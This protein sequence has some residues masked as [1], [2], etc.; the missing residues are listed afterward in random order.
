MI[1][2]GYCHCGISRYR[3]IEDVVAA[4]DAAGVDAAVL[5]QHLGEFDNGYLEAVA[6]Q[7]PDRFVA[8]GLVDQLCTGSWAALDAMARAAG[9][10]GIR[11]TEAA[12]SDSFP[13]CARAVELGL[14]ALLDLPSG[15]ARMRN[16]V[17]RLA[18]AAAGRPIVISH[19]GYP[20]VDGGE[21]VR[22]RAILEL[23]DVASTHVLV[24]G[25]GMFCEFPYPELQALTVD[26]VQRY[27]AERVMWGSN[28]PESVDAATYRRDLD[29][30]TGLA[31]LARPQLAT[32]LAGETARRVW[33]EQ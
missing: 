25:F 4:M 7:R 21:L 8:V 9:I 33:F 22:G 16:E 14:I 1:V 24:S 10:R 2:D 13:L 29:L 3:P 5:V 15:A 20:M 17:E 28:F 6:R 11:L 27:G 32:A 31:A 12:L 19:L 26:V 30:L 18:E 23:A